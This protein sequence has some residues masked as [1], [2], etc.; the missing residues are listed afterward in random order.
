MEMNDKTSRHLQPEPLWELHPGPRVT[1]VSGREDRRELW[2][3]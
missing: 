1:Q 3:L 2:L